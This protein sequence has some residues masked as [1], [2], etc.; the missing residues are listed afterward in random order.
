MSTSERGDFW[1]SLCGM[2]CVTVLAVFRCLD[3]HVALAAVLAL[4]GLK[5]GGHIL[6]NGIA[7]VESRRSDTKRTRNIVREEIENANRSDPES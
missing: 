5:I 1:L 4:A 3:V 2:A 6:G 7:K